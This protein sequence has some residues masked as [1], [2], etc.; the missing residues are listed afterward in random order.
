MSNLQFDGTEVPKVSEEGRMLATQNSFNPDMG[1]GSYVIQES[2]D[3]VRI[4]AA[5]DWTVTDMGYW[6]VY[7]VNTN[8]TLAVNAEMVTDTSPDEVISLLELNVLPQLKATDYYRTSKVGPDVGEYSTYY[9]NFGGMH[10]YYAWKAVGDGLLLM[11]VIDA[12]NA[13]PNTALTPIFDRIETY[14]LEY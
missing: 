11:T 4:T 10:M 13:N 1:D 12:R 14:Q 2:G 8:D 3:A 7:F 5:E 9:V 6:Y